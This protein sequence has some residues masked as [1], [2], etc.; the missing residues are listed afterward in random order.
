MHLWSNYVLFIINFTN[1]GLNYVLEDQFMAHLNLYIFF[2]LFGLVVKNFQNC[3]I[4]Q[5]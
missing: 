2:S 4:F 5:D 1:L 3:L